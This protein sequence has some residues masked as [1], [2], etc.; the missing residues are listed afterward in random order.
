MNNY[1][2]SGATVNVTNITRMCA[3]IVTSDIRQ[4]GV[5]KTNTYYNKLSWRHGVGVNALVVIN[6]ALYVGPG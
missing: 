3:L 2:G 5:Q 4:Q 1:S 6:E